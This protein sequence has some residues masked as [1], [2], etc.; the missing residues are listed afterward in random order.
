MT[1]YLVLH[2]KSSLIWSQIVSI[3]FLAFVPGADAQVA[4]RRPQLSLVEELKREFEASGE[5]QK[6]DAFKRLAPMIEGESGLEGRKYFEIYSE[7]M[8]EI[9]SAPVERGVGSLI[10]TSSEVVIESIYATFRPRLLAAE[11][12]LRRIPDRMVLEKDWI[13]Q[14]IDSVFQIWESSPFREKIDFDSMCEGLLPY[15]VGEERVRPWLVQARL[16]HE[17]LIGEIG[18]MPSMREAMVHIWYEAWKPVLN[19]H[20]SAPSKLPDDTTYASLSA[21]QPTDCYDAAAYHI[22]VARAAGIPASMYVVPAWGNR[23]RAEHAWAD[24]Y[25]VDGVGI[26]FE[27]RLD[28]VN[29]KVDSNRILPASYIDYLREDLP[30]F[31]DGLNAQFVKRI[32]KV[33]RKV[34]LPATRSTRSASTG[35]YIDEYLTNQW[36][37]VTRQYV[38]ACDVTLE[39]DPGLSG[40]SALLAV[41]SPQGW[42]PIDVATVDEEGRAAFEAIGPNIVYVCGFV[43]DG[44]VHPHGYP[45]VLRQNGSLRSLEPDLEK[46][47]SADVLRKYPLFSNTARF[48]KPF[49]KGR[50]ILAENED[51]QSG[52]ASEYE[53]Q[54]LERDWIEIELPPNRFKTIQFKPRDGAVTAFAAELELIH[55]GGERIECEL[56]TQDVPPGG[57]F[58]KLLDRDYATYSVL[59]TGEPVALKLPQDKW[60]QT[61]RIVPRSDTNFVEPGDLYELFYFDDGWKSCGQKRA[62]SF[63][64][65]YDDLPTGALF[66][67]RNLSKGREERPFTL[68]DG[69]QVFW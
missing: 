9:R 68:E 16:D 52:S 47:E 40:R 64:L 5:L 59:P 25:D 24:A 49:W 32:P 8:T 14:H 67:L 61:I 26:A 34:A 36:E 45:F 56:V 2:D 30:E 57:G 38:K 22:F 48:R 19:L 6:R 66:W 20:Y 15:R 27:E 35:T 51:A 18:K 13:R 11:N 33:F 58:E 10:S 69:K 50:L 39:L 60:L 1:Q 62:D 37:D 65:S 4:L 43:E 12:S 55:S 3:V 31:E 44:E 21:R 23:M 28:N 53:I 46:R 17:A 54:D 29:R 41:F 7:M 63:H 42:D